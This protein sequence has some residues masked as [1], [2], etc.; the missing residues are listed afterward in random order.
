MRK[1]FGVIF[2][3]ILVTG[4]IFS[5]CAQPAAPTATPAPVP[6]PGPAPA[7]APTPAP[8]P[9]APAAPAQPA[10][11][12]GGILKIITSDLPNNIGYPPKMDATGMSRSMMWAERLMDV[13][14]NGDLI[15]VLAESWDFGS[16]GLSITFH[17]R[18]GVKFHDGTDFN[19][20]AV[21]WNYTE[22][23]KTGAVPD[24]RYIKSIDVLDPYTI[25]FSLTKPN[26]HIIYDI[27]RP[28]MISPTAVTQNGADWAIT[29]AV[30]TA[31]FKVVDFQ[32]GVSMKLEKFAGYWRPG[33]P[34][35]DGI[36][37][38]TVKEPSTAAMLIQAGQAD[39]W[40]LAT[41]Q[42]ASD[43]RGKGFPVLVGTSTFNN[44]YPDSLNAK[45]PFADKKVR[46]AV[47]YAI[48]RKAM[49]GAL[50]FGFTTP[51]DQ[52]APPNTSGYNPAYPARAFNPAKAKQLLAEAGYPNGFSTSM[53]LTSTALNMGTAIK[54]YLGDIGIKVELNVLDLGKYYANQFTAGWTGLHLGV[55]AV[56]PEYSVAF[57]HH[58]GPEPDVKFA[59]LAKTPEFLNS[60][61]ATM[62]AKD[63][64]TMRTL[65]RAMV[66]QGSLDAIAIP[67]YTN[68]ALTITGPTV[69]STYTK[70]VYWTGWRISD[71]WIKQK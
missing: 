37:I 67:V 23:M 53:E 19:A 43:L 60:V 15:P 24:A 70:E 59:S 44:I 54:N 56:S 12:Y 13:A 33:R 7:P 58:L 41:Q 27:W 18:K 16:D 40:L 57:I 47:E 3:L 26:S 20:D 22:D 6:A 46:E 64:A 45:S 68:P 10:V 8:T 61:E 34:Y 30:T 39:M 4:L 71:D 14:P 48:D 21:K 69:M 55:I 65:T 49:S 1:L 29:H 36:E 5:S 32:T 25:R 50:G 62:A 52:L 63:I 35:M 17:L 2:I 51:L 31:P 9:T 28:W 38:K 11:Q 66:T 42:E